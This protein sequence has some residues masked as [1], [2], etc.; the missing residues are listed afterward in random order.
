M[1]QERT[2]GNLEVVN[3]YLRAVEAG[4]TGDDLA[5]FFASEVVQ[6]EFPNRLLPAIANRD[7]AAILEGAERGQQVVAAQHFDV[8]RA[9]ELGDT[10][11]L[12]VVWT[13]RLKIPLGALAAGDPM[14]AYIAIFIDLRDGK[15]VAQRNYDCYPAF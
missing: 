3:A 6:T 1:H 12:E 13:A 5:R 9:Y 14:T 10:V 8:T 11:A 4:A 2:V 7:L 15:I